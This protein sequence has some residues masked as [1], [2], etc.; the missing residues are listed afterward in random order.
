MKFSTL[1][2]INFIP[3]QL[4]IYEETGYDI[5]ILTEANKI[6]E[7]AMWTNVL[8]DIISIAQ[9]STVFLL[10]L[11]NEPKQTELST[12]ML[13]FMNRFRKTLFNC[14]SFGELTSIFGNTVLFTCV[15]LWFDAIKSAATK[16]FFRNL[17]IFVHLITERWSIF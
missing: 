15:G 2:K 6:I 4:Q 14:D 16:N 9:K 7:I 5:S 13:P 8:R 17:S 11:W 1:F 3:F 10:Y 12:K